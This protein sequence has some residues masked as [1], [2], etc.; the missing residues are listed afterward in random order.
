MSDKNSKS[1]NDLIIA[2][3]SD[4]ALISAA[5]DALFKKISVLIEESRRVMYAQANAKTVLLF[6]EIGRHINI[7]ILENERA[8]YGK[9]IVSALPT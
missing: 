2:N 7:D 5:S 3:T 4:D 8:A 6:W 9:K 1:K